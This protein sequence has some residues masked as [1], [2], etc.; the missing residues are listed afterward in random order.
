MTL[1][2]EGTWK[3]AVN[4]RQYGVPHFHIEGRGFRCSVRIAAQQP[5]IGMAPAPVLK[6]ACAW[7]REHRV[8]LMA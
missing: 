2:H 8:E 1:L 5:I 4:G 3:I 7:A 6:I